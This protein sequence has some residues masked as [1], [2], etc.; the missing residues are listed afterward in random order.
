[1]PSLTKNDLYKMK[2]LS[3]YIGEE[4][5]LVQPS[6][7]KREFEFSSTTEVLA[8][9]YYPKFFSLTAIVEGF[10]EKFEIFRPNFWK[11][12]LGIRRSGSELSFAGLTSNFF[13][14][15]GKI[16][17]SNGKI[18]NLKFGTFKRN[19]EI[20]SETGELLIDIKTLFS[21]KDKNVV[22]VH[23]SSSLVDDNPW[24]IMMILYFLIENKK[25]G[26]A[27]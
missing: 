6:L 23:R 9:M 8:K 17:L 16:S 18:L 5:K 11:T 26:A 20:Y 14:T 24:I 4:L 25:S 19:C 7:F 21:F 13:R 27:A 15:K 1:M 10:G 3:K 12:E 22:T 2:P